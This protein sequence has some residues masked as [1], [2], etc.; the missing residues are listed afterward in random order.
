MEQ[1]KYLVTN[2]TNQNSSQEEI[3]SRLKSGNACHH[4]VQNLLSSSLLSKTL[5]SKV[6]RTIILS[7]ALNGC[8]TWSLIL[9][10]ERKLRFF[11]NGVLRRIFGPKRG[12]VT[13]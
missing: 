2:L 3:K 13:G 1:F 4:S 8:E 12:E 6:H 10:E 5:N 7:V 11:E 9:R